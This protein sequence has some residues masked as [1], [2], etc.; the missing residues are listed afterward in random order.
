[1]SCPYEILNATLTALTAEPAVSVSVGA[2]STK[3]I[4]P[5]GRVKDPDVVVLV[6]RISPAVSL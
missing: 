1:M 3:V 6:I 5:P 2:L 4:A